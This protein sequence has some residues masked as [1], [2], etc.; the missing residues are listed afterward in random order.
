MAVEGH[1]A[2]RGKE[3]RAQPA[4][5]RG[6]LTLAEVVE[7]QARVAGRSRHGVE[8]LNPPVLAGIVTAVLALV[9]LGLTAVALSGGQGYGPRLAETQPASHPAASPRAV[10]SA[11]SSV[12]ASQA[13]G[14]EFHG[15]SSAV[16]GP[17]ELLAGDYR[18]VWQARALAD[19]CVFSARLRPV[20][21][22]TLALIPAVSGPHEAILYGSA[23]STLDGGSYFLDVNGSSCEWRI[24]FEAKAEAV[25]PSSSS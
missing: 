13:E 9:V 1:H 16:V 20:D 17:I 14:L 21:A 6:R 11:S 24:A 10:S 8:R 7:R 15:R 2:G 25:S 23:Q 3:S 12:A 4:E 18:V 5:G 19:R 22:A